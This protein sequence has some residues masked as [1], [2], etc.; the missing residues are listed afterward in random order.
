MNKKETTARMKCEK[1]SVTA[2][3]VRL[4]EFGDAVVA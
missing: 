4:S 2:A 3:A 1:T